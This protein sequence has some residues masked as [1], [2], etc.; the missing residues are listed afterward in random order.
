[1]LV[2][3]DTEKQEA[4]NAA[5]GDEMREEKADS[6]WSRFKEEILCNN[7]NNRVLASWLKELSLLPAAKEDSEK[8]HLT[9]QIPSPLHKQWALEHI[10]PLLKGRAAGHYGKSCQIDFQI[11]PQ[12]KPVQNV[13]LPGG[14]SKTVFFNP[15]YRF[16]N[17]IVG[18]HNNDIAYE[19][20]HALAGRNSDDLDFNPLFIYGPSGVGKT[21]LLNAL[22]QEFFKNHSGKR[23]HYLSAEKFLNECIYSIQKREMKQFQKK[24]RSQCDLLLLDD[25]QMIARGTVVQEEFFH[26]FNELFNRSIPVVVCCDS[27]P[28]RVPGLEERL[29]TRMEGGL[30]VEMSYPDLETRVAILRS[31]M[32]KKRLILSEKVIFQIAG[33][34]KKSIREIEGVLNK[35]KMLSDLKGGIVSPEY[36]NGILERI[37]P[38]PLTASEIQKKISKKFHISVEDMLS[39]SRK[40]NTVLARQLAMYFIKKHLK[41]SLSD[42]GRIFGGKDHSTVMNGFKKIDRLKAN[43]SEFQAI[44]ED[45]QREI[46]R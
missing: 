11:L 27:P 46:Q 16:E 5:K 18:K 23:I 3:N 40:K 13:I 14:R 24:Y 28:S 1:M 33:N 7:P 37:T 22:G 12:S 15:D 8:I 2:C 29:R 19:A 9:L 35:I 39:I 32:E 20:C 45:L 34:C 6:F 43:D 38:P 41:K 4:K 31:K 10:I 42:I 26:T 30:V 21:H 17:F 44:F 25:I 36:I